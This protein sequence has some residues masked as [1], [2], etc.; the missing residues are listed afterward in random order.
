MYPP[1]KS[2]GFCTYKHLSQ[3]TIL[4]LEFTKSPDEFN[5]HLDFVIGHL[6]EAED[7]SIAKY[8]ELSRAIRDERTKMTNSYFQN[9]CDYTNS[10]GK[11][12][13]FEV[14]QHMYLPELVPLREAAKLFALQSL[15]E[16]PD[17]VTEVTSDPE[18]ISEALP[19]EAT[20]HENLE[21]IGY[22]PSVTYSFSLD[23]L[24][25]S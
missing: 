17:E 8:P 24:G 3:A 23:S 9:L 25:N 15:G 11:V 13:L 6:G 2:C 16:S 7:Q 14:I 5:D 19:I 20:Y 10:E 18:V 12:N 21:Y 1:R 22:D 4:L